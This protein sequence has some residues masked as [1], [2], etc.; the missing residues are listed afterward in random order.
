MLLIDP[1]PTTC[2][3]QCSYEDLRLDI[4]NAQI[5]TFKT[6]PSSSWV[7]HCNIYQ[8]TV[9]NFKSLLVSFLF[10]HR[11]SS[12][13]SHNRADSACRSRCE[14]RVLVNLALVMFKL[15]VRDGTDVSFFGICG[16]W[17][18]RREHAGHGAHNRADS[19]VH[20]LL[21]GTADDFGQSGT[22]VCVLEILARVENAG[23]LVEVMV[24]VG[25]SLC[26]WADL[27]WFV[28][29]KFRVSGRKDG[30]GGANDGTDC[31]GH[32]YGKCELIV[33]ECGNRGLSFYE[34]RLK[35][36]QRRRFE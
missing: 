15:C 16:R 3:S 25:G 21:L 33:F 28:G 29:V 9:S 18:V 34:A 20:S 30:V 12:L 27:A 4:P 31:G 14:A 23:V 17:V 35:Y 8:D 26:Y 24:V 36:I 7:N 10:Q 1:M 2:N 5:I 13:L 19:L 32:G 11:S 6:D 22:V